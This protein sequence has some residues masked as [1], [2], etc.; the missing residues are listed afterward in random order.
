MRFVLSLLAIVLV[1]VGLAN[2]VVYVGTAASPV[3]VVISHPVAILAAGYLLTQLI[4]PWFMGNQSR[5]EAAQREQLLRASGAPLAAA[6]TGGRIGGVYVS[7]GLLWVKV[8]PDGILLKPMLMR[9]SAVLNSEVTGLRVKQ[10]R[11]GGGP[12]IE[13]TCSTSAVNSPVAMYVAPTSEVAQ[14]IEQITR[15][16]FAVPN[17]TSAAVKR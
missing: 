14:A 12:Y 5:E 3:P 11:L 13:V 7:R 10:S 9:S 15:M 4:L 17:G 1:V 16:R 2:F 8:F 6:N